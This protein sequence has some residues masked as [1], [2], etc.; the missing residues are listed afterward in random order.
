MLGLKQ[1]INISALKSGNSKLI[2][3]KKMIFRRDLKKIH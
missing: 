2:I 1:V 3:R